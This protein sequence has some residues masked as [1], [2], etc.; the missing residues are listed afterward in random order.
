MFA[1]LIAAATSVVAFSLPAAADPTQ[2]WIRNDYSELCLTIDGGSTANNA[3][4]VQYT[5]DSHNARYWYLVSV[6]G[7]YYNI[8]NVNSG[9]CL[10]IAGGSTADNAYAVQYNCDGHLSRNWRV[11]GT[12]PYVKIVNQNSGKCLTPAGGSTANLAKIVQYTCDSHPSRIWYSGFS[13]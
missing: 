12:R 11:S 9:K 2:S 5:C 6:G 4:A 3:V 7:G 10:T 8:R 1:A 13:W